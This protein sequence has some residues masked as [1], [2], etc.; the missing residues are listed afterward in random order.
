MDTA[1]TRSRFPRNSSRCEP[2]AL[3]SVI[4]KEY[5]FKNGSALLARKQDRWLLAVSIRQVNGNIGTTIFAIDEAS[6]NKDAK[7]L[8]LSSAR[9]AEHECD[10]MMKLRGWEP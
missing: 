7:E 5:N 9:V 2:V 6:V 3:D 10:G 8:G 4:L 1:S